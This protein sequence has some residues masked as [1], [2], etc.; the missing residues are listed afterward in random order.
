MVTLLFNEALQ[1]IVWLR[2]R[3]WVVPKGV[4][5]FVR[6]GGEVESLPAYPN[7][8][9]SAR[10]R[11]WMR[12]PLPASPYKGEKTEWHPHKSLKSQNFNVAS[13]VHVSHPA[14]ELSPQAAAGLEGYM[15][16]DGCRRT[17]LEWAQGVLREPRLRPRR[18]PRSRCGEQTHRPRS[19]C[20]GS[21]RLTE[22]IDHTGRAPRTESR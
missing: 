11:P 2:G 21:A 18:T 9:S 19:R 17:K 7:H 5:S 8:G 22:P 14:E 15:R 4:P 20:R 3:T 13:P 10:P 1:E 6:G 12:L 16:T